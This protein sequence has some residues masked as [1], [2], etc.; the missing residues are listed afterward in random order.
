MTFDD[1][2]R[3]LTEQRDLAQARWVLMDSAYEAHF[4]DD[5]PPYSKIEVDTAWVQWTSLDQAINNIE[6]YQEFRAK[7]ERGAR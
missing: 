5:E 6:E 4:G 2:I 3:Y 7:A 1:C